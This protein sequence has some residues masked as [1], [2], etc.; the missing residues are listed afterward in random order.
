MNNLFKEEEEKQYILV[1]EKF[2]NVFQEMFEFV[3]EF[4]EDW[5]ENTTLLEEQGDCV[6]DVVINSVHENVSILKQILDEFKSLA[7]Q[8]MIEKA[9]QSTVTVGEA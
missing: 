6:T 8:D 3:E 7:E 1:D 5:E 2:V 4:V 9:C